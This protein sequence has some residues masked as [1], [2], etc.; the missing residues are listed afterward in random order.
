MFWHKNEADETQRLYE[1]EVAKLNKRINYLE[2][3]IRGVQH[4]GIIQGDEVMYVLHQ[5]NNRFG[6]YFLPLVK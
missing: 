5:P 3:R 2:S 4:L 6:K 1:K